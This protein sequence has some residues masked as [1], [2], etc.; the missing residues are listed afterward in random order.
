[1]SE[2]YHDLREQLEPVALLVRN[3]DTQVPDG[4]VGRGGFRLDDLRG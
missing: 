4:R 2:T 3:Q 1:V